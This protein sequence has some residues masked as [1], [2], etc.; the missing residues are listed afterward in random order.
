V[1][2]WTESLE[3]FKMGDTVSTFTASLIAEVC[4]QHDYPKEEFVE[5]LF[6]VCDYELE[7]L[8]SYTVHLIDMLSD[9]PNETPTELEVDDLVDYTLQHMGI[10]VNPR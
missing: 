1:L 10:D 7:F 5:S 2:D 6:E 3:N 8:Q 4:K 9:L